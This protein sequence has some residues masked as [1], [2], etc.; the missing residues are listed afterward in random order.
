M[1]SISGFHSLQV[2]VVVQHHYWKTV[3]YPEL[4]LLI[5]QRSINHIFVGLLLGS[6]FCPIVLCVCSLASKMLSWYCGFLV[7]LRSLVVLKYSELQ[8]CST[9]S[10]SFAFPGTL[11]FIDTH[12]ITCWAFAW[13]YVDSEGQVGINCYFKE[14]WLFCPWTWIVS[15]FISCSLFLSKFYNSNHLNFIYIL[16]DLY[17]RTSFFVSAKWYLCLNFIARLYRKATDFFCLL[18]FFLKCFCCHLLR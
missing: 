11:Q 16:F 6:R 17:L 3:L 4:L 9:C 15:S 18:T 8:Y 1:W 12:R 7:F 14:Y 2:V 5:C 13:N 10:G